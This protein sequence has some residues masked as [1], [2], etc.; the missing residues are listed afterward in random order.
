MPA[1]D[2]KDQQ[3]ARAF[4]SALKDAVKRFERPPVELEWFAA[5]PK[6]IR[7]S[8]RLLKVAQSDARILLDHARDAWVKERQRE[9]AREARLVELRTQPRDL[10]CLRSPDNA[11][12]T[13]QGVGRR[14]RRMRKFEAVGRAFTARQA[15]ALTP[16]SSQPVPGDVYDIH[17]LRS[18][19]IRVPK[20]PD[21]PE[22]LRGAVWTDPQLRKAASRLTRGGYTT[23]RRPPPA[24]APAPAPPP[25]PP[26]P[27]V[28]THHPPSP[29][30]KA[31][32]RAPTPEYP[33]SPYMEE[34]LTIKGY[35]DPKLAW[36]LARGRHARA[37]YTSGYLREAATC[38][39]LADDN[40]PGLLDSIIGLLYPDGLEMP[41]LDCVALEGIVD[42]C[43]GW[44]D[45]QNRGH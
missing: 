44:E 14:K 9:A 32:P 42:F 10:D 34:L 40:A 6:R 36:I 25:P 33:T 8:G 19:Q 30:P 28:I 27:P 21:T 7:R 24:P 35:V 41:P 12:S 16:A 11:G 4:E 5:L 3:A 2:A 31:R 26:L 20:R 37:P 29:V 23:P 39:Y 43:A 1:V 17:A 45:I 38:I 22:G 18:T 13:W 15:T